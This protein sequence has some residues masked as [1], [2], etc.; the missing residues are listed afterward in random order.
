[1]TARWKRIYHV[2]DLEDENIVI[3]FGFFDGSLAGLREL[4]AQAWRS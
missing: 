4:Q 2:R 3:S 1:M